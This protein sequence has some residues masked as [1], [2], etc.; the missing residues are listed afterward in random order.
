MKT[1]PMFLRM[2][3]REVLIVGGGEAAAQKARLIL[4][5]EA[6]LT[7]IADA[8][9]PELAAIVEEARATH[10]PTPAGVDRLRGAALVFA[11]SGCPALDACTATLAREAGATVNAVDQ[12]EL[13]D[14]FTPS[15]VD[16]DPVVVAIGTEGSAPV[17]ARQIKTELEQRLEPG[18]GRFVALAGRL[19]GAVAMAVPKADRR[20]FWRWVFDVPRRAHARGAERDAAAMLKAA[21]AAG[22][23][24]DRM[25]AG[26]IAL[27]GAGP[28]AADLLTLR[29]V[30]RLQEADVIFYDRLVDPAIL[31]LARRDAERVYVGK[32]PGAQDWPQDRIDRTIVAEARRGRRVVRLKGGDPSIF[33]RA[34][35]ELSAARNAGIPVELVPG[36]TAA[37]AAAASLGRPLTERG[38]TSRLVLATA[39][40]RDGRLADDLAARLQPG[41]TLAIYMGVAQAS[42]ICAALLAAGLPAATPAEVVAHASTPH[43]RI[44]RTKLDALPGD[45]TRACIDAPA[46][47]LLRHPQEAAV[48]RGGSQSNRT[49][50]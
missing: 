14:A 27:V 41:T 25:P 12:P 10:E 48:S 16:R 1:F 50:A 37:S 26:E 35:E 18:L 21:V 11:A 33:G 32:A 29:A 44:L 22:G 4:K 24:P 15:I 36:V 34:E 23:P 40:Q 9:D 3:G 19:R 2:Q 30:Q 13:C 8:L 31:E 43:E 49:A 38:A 46:V 5:T 39:T 6:R 7:V 28:G 17:L 45:L 47:I 42:Q 20:A